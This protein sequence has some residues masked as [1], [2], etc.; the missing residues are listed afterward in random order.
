VSGGEPSDTRAREDAHVG[1][2]EIACAG[3]RGQARRALIALGWNSSIATAAVSAAAAKRWD[4][5]GPDARLDE[6]AELERLIFEA[7]R[8]CPRPKPST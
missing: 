3:I 7:L 8:C 6:D 2:R 5:A 4:A 1:A